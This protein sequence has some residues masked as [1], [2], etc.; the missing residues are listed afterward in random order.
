MQ[1][2]N[3]TA[4]LI[5][6]L[7]IA[8]LIADAISMGIGDYLSEK[9]ELQYCASEYAREKWEFENFPEGE[10]QE[11]IDIY[12]E[13]GV[14]PKDAE[15]IL[16]KMALYPDFFLEHM[17]IQELE[18]SAPTGDENPAKG[19]MVTFVAFICFGIIP[20]L[21]YVVFETVEFQSFN[22]KFLISIILTLFTLFLLGAVKA[23]I[24]ETNIFKSGFFV[25]LNGATAA[26]SSYAI[27]LGLSKLV[28]LS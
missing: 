9:A 24:T 16:R 27:G 23:K 15:L 4:E 11:M 22:P 28:H 14:E 10:I 21:S 20:L 5:L 7:G 26:A 17:M 13:K 8:N 19:G 2:A 25:M 1:G 6:V 18:M 3:L 12:V